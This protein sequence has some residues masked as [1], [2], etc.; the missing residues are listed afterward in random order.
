MLALVAGTGRLPE[1]LISHLLAEQ[2]D[3]VLC[4]LE[5]FDIADAGDLSVLSFR[6]ETL[7]TLIDTLKKKGAREVCFAGAVRRPRIDP[8]LIDAAT[9]PLMEQV[10][11]ALR[12]GDDGALRVIVSLF[13]NAGLRVR[14][15]SDVLPALLLPEGVPTRVRPSDLDG[16]DAARGEAIVAALGRADIGQ[17]CVVAEGQA[18]AIEALPGTDWMLQSL[19]LPDGERLATLP[20]GGLLYKAPK[21]GQDRRI[22]LPTIGPETL[23][24]A[25]AAG[26]SGVVIEAGGV[27]VL[28]PEKVVTIADGLGLFLWVRRSGLHI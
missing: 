28:D 7:G 8:S 16:A 13:E 21:P 6:L 24:N 10:L 5:G 20:T 12:A 15:A 2:R 19:Q 22:D 11:G 26:L 18:L 1:V 25:A 4:K 27:I 14:A 23:R 3:V 17:G 9:R